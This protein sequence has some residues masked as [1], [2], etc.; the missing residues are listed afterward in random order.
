[1]AHLNVCVFMHISPQFKKSCTPARLGP[2]LSSLFMATW[3]ALTPA[4][5]T[6]AA[7][8]VLQVN[9]HSMALALAGPTAWKV[10]AAH[11]S[12]SPVSAQMLPLAG[13]P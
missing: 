4:P 2:I 9:S 8:P 3:S 6:L 10:L 5:V 1:M 13:P 7:S 11:L 12:I